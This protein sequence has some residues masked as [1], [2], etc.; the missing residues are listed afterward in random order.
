MASV[1]R[2]KK[3]TPRPARREATERRILSATERL[4][5]D[6]SG[7]T[8]LSVE[9]L[10]S[11]AGISRSTFYSHF[12]DKGALVRRLAEEVMGELSAAADQWWTV[13]ERRRRGDLERSLAG[14][15]A[16]YS[17]HERV[18]LALIETSAYDEAVAVEYRA[19]ITTLVERASKAI[20][21]A[22]RA[23]VMRDVPA[24][25]TAAA[26]TWMVE[27]SAEQML[28]SEASPRKLASVL[29]DIVWQT[30]YVEGDEELRG[31][32]A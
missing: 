1:T 31:S 12:E 15:L 9:R 19:H 26:L 23:G 32:P 21:R 6:G 30:L 5:A 28:D 13:A 18:F 8:E 20:R 17:E 29:T 7:F 16:V 10:I 4:L 11:E 25:E 14:V 3:S 2:Q 24:R 27:R 22:Q